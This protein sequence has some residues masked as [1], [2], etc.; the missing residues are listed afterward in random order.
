MERR[1]PPP[2]S[3]SKRSPPPIFSMIGKGT[4]PLIGAQSFKPECTV[5]ASIY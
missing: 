4:R 3:G 5:S 2:I 1:H